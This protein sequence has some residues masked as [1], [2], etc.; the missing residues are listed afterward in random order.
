VGRRT[1]SIIL[2]SDG[3]HLMTDVWT[4]FGVVVGLVLVSITDWVILDPL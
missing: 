4:S 3:Q 2:E 1:N